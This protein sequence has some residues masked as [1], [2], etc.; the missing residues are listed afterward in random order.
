MA[1]SKPKLVLADDH[2]LVRE[3]LRTLLEN[4]HEVVATAG[5]GEELLE[6]LRTARADCLLL[7]LDMP[8]QQGL[9]LLPTIRKR[10]PQLR[11]LVVTMHSHGP[12]ATSVRRKGADGFVTKD[13]GLEE[14][15]FAISEV[16]AGRPYVTAKLSRSPP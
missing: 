3:A 13:T 11:I 6:V 15:T 5:S 10:Y 16:C 12:L 14:L 7:D 1:K 9:T 2:R 8:G 4:N